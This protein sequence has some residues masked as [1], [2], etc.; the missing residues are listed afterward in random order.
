MF[1]H[2]TIRVSDRAESERLSRTVL[3]AIGRELTHAS[4]ALGEWD[5]FSLLAA[6]DAGRVT[7][8]LHIGFAAP[9]APTSTA[10]GARGSTRGFRDDGASRP[11]PVYGER[12]YGGFR[13]DPDGNMHLAFPAPDRA[14]VD[15]FH[16]AVTGAGYRDNGPPGERPRYHPGYYGAFVHDPDGNN[17]ELVHHDRR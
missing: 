14:T 9:S 7:R 10:S 8:N 13:L 6:E 12:Y 16:A 3:A 1:D 2:V 17:I 15:R 11:R 4:A 5:D